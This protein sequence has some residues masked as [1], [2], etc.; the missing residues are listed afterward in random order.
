MLNLFDDFRERLDSVMIQAFGKR[1]VLWGY[2]Y[3]GRFLEWYA[4]YYHS[5]KV[6]FI[7]T[8]DWSRGIPYNFPLFRDSLF[9]FDYADVKDAVVWL[10]IPES[11]IITEKLKEHGYIKG[12][13]WFSFLEIVFGEDYICT[14]E[15][16][17]D[18]FRKRKTGMRDVQFLEW[19]EYKYGCNF[20]SAI[21]SSCFLDTMEGAHSYRVT[22]QKEIFPILDKCHCIPGKDDGIF[23]FGCGKGGA[24]VAFL[25]YGFSRVGGVEYE[26]KIYEELLSNFQKL[27]IDLDQHKEIS[28][29]HGDAAKLEKELDDYNWFY[30][31]DPFEKSIFEKTMEHIC[32][33]LRRKPRRVHIINI[34]P[35][36]HHIV[37]ES[38]FFDL[39]NQ[40]CVAIRQKV[41][42]VFVTRKEYET[43]GEEDAI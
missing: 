35:K 13:S 8:E 26:T 43:A 25:D 9:D 31:F 11:E 23:D 1:I 30:Y 21:D 36:Y 32:D 7:I 42:D 38:G 39:T 2:G 17:E 3:T 41:V 15:Q 5:I 18:I 19:L 33:S 22:T 28:C 10:T 34:N 24:M 20:V 14:G 12:K 29:I 27:N 4:E 6:D 37:K 40:F 16:T